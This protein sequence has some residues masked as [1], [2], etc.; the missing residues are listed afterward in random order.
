MPENSQVEKIYK[1][2]V[3]RGVSKS[4]AAA[5]AQKR[6]GKNLKYGLPFGQKPKGKKK[7]TPKK[8]AKKDTPMHESRESRMMKRKEMMKGMD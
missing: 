6:T 2:M 5:T 4:E 1:A 7:P 3:G 8:K